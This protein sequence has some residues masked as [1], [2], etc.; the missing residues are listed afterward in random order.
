MTN[1]I[2]L[3]KSQGFT[4]MDN[5]LYEALIGADLSGRELRV[6][7]AVHRQTSGYNVDSARIAASVIA[8][9]TGIRREHVSRMVSELLRQRVLYRVGGSKGALGISPS[10]EWKIDPK[11]N[12]KSKVPEKAQC[13]VFGTSLVPFSAHYKERN[14]NT[15]SDEVVGTPAQVKP[16]R[17]RKPAFGMSQMLADNPH[18]IPDQLLIDWLSLRKTKRAP[19]TQTVWSSLNAEL[20]KCADLGITAVDAMTEALSA[21]WHGFKADWIANR[22]STRSPAPATSRH[23]GFADRDYTV[24]LTMREDGT[25]AL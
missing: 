3:H 13:A 21:G 15:T 5:D 24:G 1:I 11:D 25:Y 7:L 2:Q 22:V 9:M 18:Q 8:D 6:A 20:K 17:E 14:T 23:H 16:K 12:P 4:R 19:V 10:S